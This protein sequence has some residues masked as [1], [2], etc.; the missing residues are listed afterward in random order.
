MEPFCASNL[1]VSTEQPASKRVSRFMDV[2]QCQGTNTDRRFKGALWKIPRLN[3]SVGE[4]HNLSSWSI[5]RHKERCYRKLRKFGRARAHSTK[6]D[7][8]FSRN[9]SGRLLHSGGESIQEVRFRDILIKQA[10]HSNIGID[11]FDVADV[12]E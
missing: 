5:M 9:L 10:M 12:K 11:E 7:A 1:K 8:V 6:R 3:N 4:I 2:M